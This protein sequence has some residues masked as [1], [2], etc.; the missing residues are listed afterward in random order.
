[1]PWPHLHDCF[2]W[3]LSINGYYH[4]RRSQVEPSI[5]LLIILERIDK[6]WPWNVTG[7]MECWYE[8][9]R[10]GDG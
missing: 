9:V 6:R 2:P 1:L 4:G 8:L 5:W 7:E 10:Q 3:T